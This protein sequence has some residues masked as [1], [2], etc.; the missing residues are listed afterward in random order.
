M[1][2]KLSDLLVYNQGDLVDLQD[3]GNHF[4]TDNVEAA[5]QKLATDIETVTV[6]PGG[7]SDIGSLTQSMTN[8]QTATIN[9]SEA[10]DT[11]EI[12]VV[13]EIPR[14]GVI[15]SDWSV[16]ANDPIWDLHDSAPASS[17]TPGGTTGID[18][19]FTLATGNWQSDD[20][21]KT[22]IG[23]DGRAVITSVNAG[24]ATCDITKDFADVT[25][26]LSGNWSLGDGNFLN[27]GKFRACAEDKS[28]AITNNLGQVDTTNFV[29]MNSMTVTDAP[30][31]GDVDYAFSTDG[32]VT[33]QIVSKGDLDIQ[34]SCMLNGVDEYLSRTPSSAGNRKTWTFSQWFKLSGINSGTTYR[35]FGVN[36]SPGSNERDTI[37]IYDNKIY[38]C[39]GVGGTDYQV[40]FD[41]VLRDV[42]AW[43][44]FIVVCDTT[45]AVESD[46]IKV[47][48][49]GVEAPYAGA[50]AYPPQNMDTGFSGT[51]AHCIGSD[52]HATSPSQ[53]Y[54]GYFSD[55]VFLDG[56]AA[57]DAS[58]FGEFNSDNIWIPKDTS[59]LDYS[60]TNSFKLEFSDPAGLAN[61]SSG[62]DNHWTGNNTSQ[63]NNKF[64]DTPTENYCVLNP[65][66]TPA[67]YRNGNTTVTTAVSGTVPYNQALYSTFTMYTGQFYWE[68]ELTMAGTANG[69]GIGILANEISNTSRYNSYGSLGSNIYKTN[70]VISTASGSI[71]VGVTYTAGDIIGVA[72]DL[73]AN[74]IYFSKNGVWVNG[75][76]PVAGTNGFDIRELGD[77]PHC[78]AV[79]NDS[80][81]VNCTFTINCGQKSFQT[82]PPAGFLPVNNNNLTTPVIP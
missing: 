3:A 50:S 45:Q 34:N 32:K 72:V 14:V 79:I 11:P 5:L 67:T 15:N 65:L 4:T 47:Y 71:N 66:S 1:A 55:I 61:D 22:I 64:N 24:I 58:S 10:S 35:L 74:K 41:M 8:G 49:S 33:W 7:A 42:S 56:T 48:I 40:S 38:V 17:V 77:N 37:Y 69:P 23:N 9:L 43:T 29:D 53:Y 60:G 21:G 19:N 76:D 70:G 52:S 13:K 30:L 46:R 59:A 36:L 44:N 75:A 68:V 26:I 73:N 31:G 39:I 80:V 28:V 51:G 2:L 62:N 57:T 18:I 20:V 82:S 63:A 81:S 25:A 78:P 6:S 54:D 16:D 27:D 12:S